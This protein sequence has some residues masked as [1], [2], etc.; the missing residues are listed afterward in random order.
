MDLMKM[1]LLPYVSAWAVL[2][3]IVMVLA[4]LR[5]K[6][7]DK[8]DDSLKLSDGETAHVVKQE[9]LARKLAKIELWGKSLTILLIVTGVAL[10]LLYGWQMWEASSTAGLH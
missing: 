3:V 1:D 6:I 5:R 7:A 10:G 9:Q 2:G 4:L 8:E